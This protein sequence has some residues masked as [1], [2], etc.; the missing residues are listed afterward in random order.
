MAVM[1]KLSAAHLT[2]V[3]ISFFRFVIGG[4]L[5]AAAILLFRQKIRPDGWLP[6]ILRAL[7]GS[8]SMI[9]YYQAIG[10]TSGGRA[11]LLNNL[12]PFF[13]A[14]F[15]GMFFR[16]KFHPLQLVFML[17]SFA[18]TVVIFYDGSH[19]PLAGNL[20]ALAS[21]L[22]VGLS[23]NF[24][25]VARE[26]NNTFLL[27]FWICLFGTLFSA[28]FMVTSLPVLKELRAR[29]WLLVCGAAVV[30]FAAQSLFTWGQKYMTA[31]RNSVISF[32]KIPATLF[33]SFLLLGEVMTPRFWIGCALVAAGLI[34]DTL[35]TRS[36]HERN[37]PVQPEPLPGNT[38]TVEE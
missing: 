31:V 4:S 29:D 23:V 26:K 17:V 10:L 27:Y 38:G 21:A 2:G 37:R 3:Q 7:L 30:V 36:R 16:E 32:L 35:V 20:M 11:T 9:I 28:P 5:S 6:V 18:G 13:V 33:L 8:L 1:V 34:L 14:L 22:I 25:K 19:Y 24:M 12:Y 15:G